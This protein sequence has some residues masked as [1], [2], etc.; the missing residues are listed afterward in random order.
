MKGANMDHV[1]ESLVD[2]KD[3]ARQAEFRPDIAY[4]LL[5]IHEDRMFYVKWLIGVYIGIAAILIAVLR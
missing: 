5:K 4:A 2:A 3:H 1:T